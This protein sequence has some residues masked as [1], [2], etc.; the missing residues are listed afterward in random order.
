MARVSGTTTYTPI[1]I[2]VIAV[3]KPAVEVQPCALDDHML[4][5]L[6]FDRSE[7]AS[8]SAELAGGTEAT[9]MRAWLIGNLPP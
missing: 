3:A 8:V 4:R 1:V 7:I 9:R 6:G 2:A 5:D